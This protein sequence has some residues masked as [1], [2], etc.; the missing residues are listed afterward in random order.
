MS[1][2]AQIIPYFGRWPEWIDLYLYSCGRNRMIDFIVYTDCDT[3]K[4]ETYENVKFVKISFSDYCDLVSKR[5]GIK[6][7]IDKPYKLTDLKPFL[8]AIHQPELNGYDFWSFGD[9]DLV[10]GDMSMLVNEKNLGKY[11][12]ITTHSYHIAGHFTIIRNI[13]K[14][15]NLCFKIKNWEHRLSDDNHYAFD[16]NEWSLITFPQLKII[17][18]IWNKAISKLHICSFFEYLEKANRLATSN[19]LF[20]EY[21]TSPAPKND[22]IWTYDLKSGS[23]LSPSGLKLPYLHFLFFKK[24]QWYET[25]NYWKDGYYNIQNPINQY[26]KIL[27]TINGIVGE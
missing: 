10:Y 20:S 8:G 14:Y 2:V 24:T 18:G 9:I 15:N 12:I 11:D 17:R 23:I 1:R 4:L 13:P 21:Y 7:Q 6:Y 25:D 3:N 22:E 16:E 19:K 27:F 5:I 26:K